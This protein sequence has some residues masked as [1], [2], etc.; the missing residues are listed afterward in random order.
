LVWQAPIEWEDVDI[1]PTFDKYGRST[2]PQA[3]TDSINE[4]KLALKGQLRATTV[5]AA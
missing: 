1:S 2:I 4:T 5:K 3:A